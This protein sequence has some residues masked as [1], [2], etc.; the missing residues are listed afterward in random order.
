[1]AKS[2]KSI[3]AIVGGIVGL[4]TIIGASIG[5]ATAVKQSK[6]KHVWNDGEITVEATCAEEGKIVFKCEECGKRET[7]KI[8]TLAHTWKFVE[9]KAP[10]CTE[11]GHTEYTYCE[12]CEAYKNDVEPQVLLAEGHT[13][14]ELEAVAATCTETGLTAGKYCTTCEETTVEQRT[15]AAK[16]HTLVTVEAVAATCTEAGLTA[17]QK[18]STC[19]TV[20]IEQKEVSAT[21][22]VDADSDNICD[23]CE[24]ESVSPIADY[25]ETEIGE[26]GP[27]NKVSGKYFRIYNGS[28][29]ASSLLTIS[30]VD[31]EIVYSYSN[32][33]QT[34]VRVDEG[35]L[36]YKCSDYV[37]I[38]ISDTASY[39]Y[40]TTSGEEGSQ[41]FGDGYI[42]SVTGTVKQLV[43]G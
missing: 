25:V 37:E 10:T 21:G 14:I 17:G 13:E 38:Y 27:D 9:A 3:W 28:S 4:L 42:T 20:Y 22:H 35:V 18:C 31:G 2:K 43:K 26:A 29:L 34:I 6:C 24:F 1:M 12:V 41:L 30:M 39:Y 36:V 15:I 32:P 11:D 5:I 33:N 19:D 40:T 23:V 16:G 7:E 8:E